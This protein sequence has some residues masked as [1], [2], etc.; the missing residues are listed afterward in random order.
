MD[1]PKTMEFAHIGKSVIIKGELSGSEDLYVEGQVEGKI[2]L[3]DNSLTIGPNGPICIGS[4]PET[5][6][7][8]GG[9]SGSGRSEAPGPV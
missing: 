6:C 4:L 7:L 9:S 8:A 2:E 1:A 3:H 5:H